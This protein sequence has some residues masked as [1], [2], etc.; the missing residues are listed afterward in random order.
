VKILKWA[1]ITWSVCLTLLVALSYRFVDSVT[2]AKTF[3]AYNKI[4]VEFEE[5]SSKWGTLLLDWN[6]H[7]IPCSEKDDE[8]VT[9]SRM[10]I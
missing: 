4:F 8:P 2:H 6:G 3:C 7:P 5:G 10:N 1:F 9:V